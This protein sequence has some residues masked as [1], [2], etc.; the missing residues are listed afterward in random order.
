MV[1]ACLLP[2]RLVLHFARLF[3]RFYISH[4]AGACPGHILRNTP[5]LYA[6]VLYVCMVCC[7]A[8]TLFTEKKHKWKNCHSAWII[9]SFGYFFFFLQ[10]R[11]PCTDH[12]NERKRKIKDFILHCE[13]RKKVWSV[14]FGPETCS[15]EYLKP[16]AVFDT[17]TACRKQNH[18]DR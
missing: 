13:R 10:L 6:Y 3:L 14:F 9:K 11:L 4:S 15:T 16:H 1:G 18:A 17:L 5:T 7:V 2:A 12:R 8:V